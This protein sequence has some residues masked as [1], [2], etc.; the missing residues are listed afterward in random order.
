[1]QNDI[2][3]GL[4]ARLSSRQLRRAVFLDRD[5]TLNAEIGHLRSVQQLALLPGAAESVRRLNRSG[6]LAVAVTN[7]PVLARGDVSWSG[8][9][10]IH[11]ELDRQLGE[12]GAYLDRLYLCPHHPHTGFEGEVLSLKIVCNCRKPRTG[13]ID[14]AVQELSIDRRKSWMIGDATSDI[15]AGKTAGLKTILLRTGQGGRDEKYD[16]QPDFVAKDIGSA[17]DWI[18]KGYPAMHRQ[19][20]AIAAEAVR[21]KTA[22]I[23]VR[24]GG[25]ISPAASVLS[26][27]MEQMGRQVRIVSVDAWLDA[28]AG[29]LDD[30][31]RAI[32]GFPG[33][34]AQTLAPYC[35]RGVGQ[36]LIPA[37]AE[38]LIIVDGAPESFMHHFAEGAYVR[39]SVEKTEQPQPSIS[40]TVYRISGDILE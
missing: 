4:P 23:A 40:N 15:L 3:K 30:L 8:I 5:G 19:L 36:G 14:Q 26:E 33:S 34:V 7:Q 6:V 25:A 18:E 13:L 38:S 1:V 10:Q 32:E 12:G 11:A 9:R 39:I 29:S 16:V 24:T 35:I 21:A 31:R 17:I 22:F 20:A 28:G 27:M 2:L 37:D